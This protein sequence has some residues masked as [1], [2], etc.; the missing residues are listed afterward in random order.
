[1]RRMTRRR[2]SEGGGGGFVE[3]LCCEYPWNY[4]LEEEKEMRAVW[5]PFFS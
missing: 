2:R 4:M 1:M 3:L 5:T